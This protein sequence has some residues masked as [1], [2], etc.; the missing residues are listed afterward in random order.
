MEGY[1]YYANKSHFSDMTEFAAVLNQEDIQ[2]VILEA[3][4][5][6]NSL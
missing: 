1:M 5:H 6:L 2:K 3:F 4:N